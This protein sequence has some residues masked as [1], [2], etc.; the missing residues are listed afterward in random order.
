MAESVNPPVVNVNPPLASKINGAQLI[1][2]IV[3]LL[4]TFGYVIPVEWQTFAL[5]ALALV[6]PVITFIFRTWFTGT[7]ASTGQLKEA[8]EDKGLDVT[9]KPAKA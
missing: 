7:E 2:F 3:G 5:Q 6:T 9:T 4:A 8:L 1:A